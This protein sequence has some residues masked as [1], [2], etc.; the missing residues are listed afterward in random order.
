LVTWCDTAKAGGRVIYGE[1]RAHRQK[2]RGI[3]PA[4]DGKAFV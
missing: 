4:S 1:V 3:T 2:K